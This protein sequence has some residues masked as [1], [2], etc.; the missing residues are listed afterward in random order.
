MI[1]ENDQARGLRSSERPLPP[2]VRIHPE[3]A[4]AKRVIAVTSGKGGVGKTQVSANIA[5]TLA[6]QGKKVLLMDADLGLASLDLALG[7][8]PRYNL[9]DVL[10]GT[11]SLDEILVTGP[12]NVQ[13]IPAC[14]GRYDVAN[15]DAGQRAA[16][17]DLIVEVARDFD[18]LIIDT[19]AG[20][21]SNAVGFASYADDVLLVTTPDPTSLRDAYAMAK[22]LHRRAGRDRIHLVANHVASEREG[23]EIHDRM[24]GIVKKF[25]MLELAYLGAIPRDEAIREC[26]ALGEPIAIKH[27]TSPAARAR[28]TFARRLR[29][30]AATPRES[31]PC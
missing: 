30:V 8:S 26:V 27:P 11:R 16:L 29:V 13:L 3:G 6:K 21:G 28:E 4:G 9:L 31:A 15:L 18:V 19:G 14:P 22:V 5:V 7:V 10:T 25:L 24:N 17:W 2:M 20:I 23:A 12:A 1:R